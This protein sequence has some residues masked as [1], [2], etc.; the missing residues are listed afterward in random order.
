VLEW[1]FF[2]LL[3]IFIQGLF[4]LFEMACVSFNKVRLQYYVSRGKKRAE[5][6]HFLLRKPSRLF[7]T[8]L[9]GVNAAL[10]TGSECSRR[11]FE[12]I[13]LDPDWAP[14]SQVILVVIFAELVPMF[15]ARKHP[16]GVA[17]F[18]SPIM[19]L[20]A[21]IFSPIIWTFDHLSQLIHWIMRKPIKAPFLLS[22]EEVMMA[23][24]EGDRGTDEFSRITDQIFTL[25]NF[26]ASDIMCPLSEALIFP[27]T[28]TLAEAKQR[29]QGR[30][31][32]ILPIYHRIIQNIVS[33]ALPRDLLRLTENQ[34]IIDEGKS[35]WF[36]TRDSS[37]LQILDQFRRNNQ[38]AA[39][40]LEAT[41]QAIGI[42]TLDTIVDLIFGP[43]GEDVNSEEATKFINRT[44]NASMTVAQFNSLFEENL[45]FTSTLTLNEL[46]LEKLEHSPSIGES[47]LI[48]NYEF[49]VLE[50]T[51]RGAKTLS[52]RSKVD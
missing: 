46:I 6:V 40:V 23:F 52:V 35:P 33:I 13:H 47:V 15:T 34:K 20:I 2:T 51:M 26:K 21:R 31:V 9:V 42:V 12:S 37:V 17:L 39:V 32:P 24:Q 50:A 41:G 7:G 29:L 49:T 16:E 36:I 5:W 14:L 30:Y 22:R 11:F 45:H 4:A 18:L 44:I 48:D 27:S 25:K 8:T 28:T 19:I 10:Q 43:E 3:A 38:S 1:F